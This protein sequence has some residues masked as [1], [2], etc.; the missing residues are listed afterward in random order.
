MI[1]A[2]I[3]G[4]GSEVARYI[5]TNNTGN[6]ARGCV[7]H[8]NML[9]GKAFCHGDSSI[10][11]RRVIMQSRQSRQSRRS[12]DAGS[13]ISTSNTVSIMREFATHCQRSHEQGSS[14]TFARMLMWLHVGLRDIVLSAFFQASTVVFG[15][16]R[17]YVHPVA[18]SCGPVLIPHS[19]HDFLMAIAK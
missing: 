10:W 13:E 19:P 17:S 9:D 7:L 3:S 11:A 14:A 8:L 1:A 5:D 4:R 16:T 15:G 2:Q 12:R 6:V 18:E